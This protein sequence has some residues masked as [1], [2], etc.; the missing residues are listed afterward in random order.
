MYSWKI[1]PIKSD[2]PTDFRW[3]WKRMNDAGAVVQKSKQQFDY[4]FDCVTDAQAHGYQPPPI[5]RLR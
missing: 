1:T 3:E 5:E 4:Y 2:S